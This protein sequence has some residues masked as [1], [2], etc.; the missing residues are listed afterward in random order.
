M[1]REEVEWLCALRRQDMAALQAL[2]VAEAEAARAAFKLG[3]FHF[4]PI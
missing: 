2:K 4:F 3:N 1:P